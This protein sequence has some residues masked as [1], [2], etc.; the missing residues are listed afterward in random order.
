MRLPWRRPLLQAQQ[1]G[2]R[3]SLTVHV[4]P[5]TAKGYRSVRPPREHAL[6]P[7][8]QV[9][10][11]TPRQH[12]H[13]KAHTPPPPLCRCWPPAH[14]RWRAAA[15][16]RCLPR[17]A[18]CCSRWSHFMLCTASSR[19]G[20]FQFFCLCLSAADAAA[21]LGAPPCCA[22]AAAPRAPCTRRAKLAA[23]SCR[24]GTPAGCL[25][26]CLP[27][28]TSIY[29]PP[30]GP[31]LVPDRRPPAAGGGAGCARCGAPAVRRAGAALAHAG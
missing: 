19:Q 22:P 18:S 17:C 14:A 7:C 3:P 6:Q 26:M 11:P 5:A 24:V 9:P 8:V 2:G 30:A 16:R 10:L 1:G 28:H 21:C 20:L 4:L 13:L 23:P 25:C 29:P 31:G 27:A 12:P 15:A